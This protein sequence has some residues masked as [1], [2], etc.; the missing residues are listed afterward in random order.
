MRHV[1]RAWAGIDAG[2]G[3]HHVVVIDHEGTRLL[4]R[5]VANTETDLMELV[6]TVQASTDDL[7]WAI[8]LRACWRTDQAFAGAAV[9]RMKK[10]MVVGGVSRRA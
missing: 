4:S 7:T 6:D 2:K 8:D 5:R 1:E 3:H 9:A 10:I